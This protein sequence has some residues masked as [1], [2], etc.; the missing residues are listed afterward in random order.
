MITLLFCFSVVDSGIGYL[1]VL[2]NAFILYLNSGR[3]IF[4]ACVTLDGS[5]KTLLWVIVLTIT[6]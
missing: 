5:L 3:T 4:S 2:F 6:I 1:D